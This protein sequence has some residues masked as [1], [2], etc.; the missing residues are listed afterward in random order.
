MVYNVSWQ[1][2]LLG[3]ITNPGSA[4]DSFCWRHDMKMVRKACFLGMDKRS[5]LHRGDE[6]IDRLVL[7]G[8]TH[9]A[10]LKHHV[11]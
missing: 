9:S 3:N 4:W 2:T 11:S 10:G 7:G 8:R 1:R 5:V 6:S